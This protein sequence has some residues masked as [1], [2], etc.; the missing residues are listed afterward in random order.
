VYRADV[1]NLV[2]GNGSYTVAG[3]PGNL[4]GGNDSQGASLVVIYR[5]ST[6]PLTTIV[7]NDGAVALD[8]TRL[9]YINTISGFAVNVPVGDAQ[10][11]YLVGDGQAERV[12]DNITWVHL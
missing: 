11:T 7:I 3:L 8:L 6:A 1:T 12:G 5:D 10:V 2:S 9:S 4:V